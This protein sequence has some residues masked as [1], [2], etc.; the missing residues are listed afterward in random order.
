MSVIS[1]WP[2]ITLDCPYKINLPARKSVEQ[3]EQEYTAKAW[4]KWNADEAR[5]KEFLDVNEYESYKAAVS[6]IQWKQ[7]YGKFVHDG[8]YIR[9][10]T[11]S[12]SKNLFNRIFSTDRPS[13]AE[14]KKNKGKT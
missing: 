1:T 5:A 13:Y 11:E 6:S 2:K 14:L 7:S 9:R 12:D 3:V 4:E 10:I 8:G